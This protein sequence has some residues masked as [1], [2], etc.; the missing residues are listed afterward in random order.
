MTSR[1][2]HW[3]GVAIAASLLAGCSPR[4]T[5]APASTNSIGIELL[6]IPSGSFV[7]GQD[8]GGDWDE[9]P[10]HRVTISSPFLIS[11]SEVTLDQFRQFRPTH[12][13]ELAGKA[14]GV[15]W[16][17]AVAFCEWLSKKEGKPYRLP[18]EAEWEYACRAGTATEF[19]SGDHPPADAGTPNPWGLRDLYDGTM[20]WCYDW[21]GPYQAGPQTDPV[22][23]D[24]GLARVVRGD[25]PDDDKVADDPK[26][27]TGPYYHRSA[28]R[29]GMPPAFGIPA[30]M[31]GDAKGEGAFGAHSIGFRV[32]QGEMPSTAPYPADVPFVRRGI[33]V[34]TQSVGQ[35]PPA[36]QP[37]FRKRYLLPIPPA[38]GGVG[39]IVRAGLHPSIRPH[40]H[41]PA[42][43]V[44][45]NGDVLLVTYTAHKTE[46]EPGVSLMAT[47]L[48]SGADEWDMP[49]PM[50]D[51]PDAND[52]SPLLWTDWAGGG[53]MYC[54][55]GS[56]RIARGA[57]PFQ[58][59]TSDDSGATW[60]EVHYPLFAGPVGPHSRQ[61]I[62]TAVRGLDGTLYVAG[63][64]DGASSV[65]WATK[66]NGRVWY[67]T[68]GRSTGRHTTYCLL[69]DGRILG[70]G[71]KNSDFEGFMPK[72][73]SGNGGKTWSESKSPFSP[74]GVGQRPCLLRLQSGRLFMAGDFQTLKGKKPQGVTQ[75]GSYVALSDDEGD[76]WRIKRI[77]VAQRRE[78]SDV[79]TLGYCVARQAPNGMIHLVTS[80][81]APCLHFELNEA[82]ILSDADADATD[83]DLI[84]SKTKSIADVK[85]FEER[86]P[87]GGVKAAWHAGIGD[88]GRYLLTGDER[89]Y[90]EDGKKQ[91]EA[92]Y[93]LGRKTGTETLYRPDGSIEWQWDHRLDGSNVWT[94]YWGNGRMKALSA[95]RN[96]RADGPAKLWDRSGK[97]ISDATFV[98]GATR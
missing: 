53:R 36:D 47:R 90:F 64:G 30:P 77:P 68:G 70:L 7:M 23:P 57:F 93:E 41:S 67:D 44:C 20:E 89:W 8:I 5:V 81:N 39:D 29:A 14:V 59:V 71:G 60:G 37:Y 82:W 51:I 26:R 46:Y 88:D 19:W 21:H 58:W 17:D 11:A 55:W 83:A 1:R 84:P 34:P 27:I 50:F 95:W 9:S 79:V 76:T 91:Y 42:L 38:S 92:R 52:A 10:A 48:R 40:N 72:V 85:P 78:D 75:S 56:P 3:V 87:S 45:P 49:E 24:R 13:V 33:K 86:Y 96:L 65:L 31:P 12:G 98:S 66:D 54:F 18:T 35:G 28:N 6:K 4:T 63:D 97:L 25:K 22:G 32:V 2:L 62:N 43:E 80:M 74:L 73:I 69:K 16:Y 61:P 94:Q 15:S